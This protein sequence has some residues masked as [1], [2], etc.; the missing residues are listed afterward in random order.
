MAFVSQRRIVLPRQDIHVTR[1]QVEL[2]E[3]LSRRMSRQKEQK[4]ILVASTLTDLPQ[5]LGL[6]LAEPFAESPTSTPMPI[7]IPTPNPTPRALIPLRSKVCRRFY[8][9]IVLLVALNKSCRH[10]ASS[11]EVTDLLPDTTRSPES[12]F[13]CFVN[14]LGHICDS[15]RGG[16]TVTAFGVLKLPNGTLQYRFGSNQLMGEYLDKARLYIIKVLDLLGQTAT[17]NLRS[18]DSQILRMALSYCSSRVSSYVRTVE[19]KLGC[20]IECCERDENSDGNGS[21]ENL[22]TNGEC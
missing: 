19:A 6:S 13:Q 5:A 1:Q 3:I 18:I 9:P 20:C 22:K 2:L 17:E 14:K 11:P 10:D 8:E 7:P 15:E 4:N 21:F 12:A 16:A